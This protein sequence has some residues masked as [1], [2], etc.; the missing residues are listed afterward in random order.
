MRIWNVWLDVQWLAD[1]IHMSRTSTRWPMSTYRSRSKHCA[2]C[3]KL[4]WSFQ[5]FGRKPICAVCHRGSF[6]IFSGKLL[7]PLFRLSILS[8]RSI[9]YVRAH[10]TMN[11]LAVYFMCSKA[12]I[13]IKCFFPHS[14]RSWPFRITSQLKYGVFGG[15]GK[16]EHRREHHSR[17]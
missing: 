11:E 12:F 6:V 1:L 8:V 2:P 7:C 5:L 16:T 10:S 9:L 14:I 13:T 3:A 4:L 17:P 15:A